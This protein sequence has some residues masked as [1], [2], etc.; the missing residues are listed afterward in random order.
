[1][2]THERR[3]TEY[4]QYNTTKSTTEGG[5]KNARLIG[6][7]KKKENTSETHKRRDYQ[8]KKVTNI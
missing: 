2:K 6:D 8:N 3:R 5:F 1:M 4:Q 7:A